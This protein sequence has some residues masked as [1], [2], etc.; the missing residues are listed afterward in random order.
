M[1]GEKAK[2]ENWHLQLSQKDPEGLVVP[3]LDS[4]LEVPH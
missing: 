1:K 3:F 2:K 4:L